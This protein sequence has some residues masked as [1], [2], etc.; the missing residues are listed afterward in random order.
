MASP[1]HAQEEDRR[2]GRVRALFRTLR[3]G[4]LRSPGRLRTGGPD[5]PGAS[6]SGHAL[7]MRARDESHTPG[8]PRHRPNAGQMRPRRTEG[9]PA[10]GWRGPDAVKRQ[11]WTHNGVGLSIRSRHRKPDTSHSSFPGRR[12]PSHPLAPRLPCRATPPL[13]DAGTTVPRPHSGRRRGKASR[14]SSASAARPARPA[15]AA[16]T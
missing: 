9:S 5:G 14:P 8:P 11:A 10:P 7:S 16:A 13:P 1:G 3:R 12:K 6:A 15:A 4:P 2:P